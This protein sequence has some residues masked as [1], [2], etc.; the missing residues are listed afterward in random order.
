M[1]AILLPVTALVLCPV[2]FAHFIR[3][4]DYSHLFDN[5]HLRRMSVAGLAAFWAKPYFNLYI[6]ITYSVWWALTMVGSLWGTLGQ[7][8]WLFHGFNLAVHLV[9]ASLVFLVLRRLLDAGLSNTDELRDASAGTI[10]VISALVF[11]IH[12]LQVETVAW[13]SELK[14]ELAALFGLLGLWFHYRS[15]AR[16]VTAT[17]FVAAMLSKPSA[18][19]FPGIVL[20]IDR[21]VL[22]ISFRKCAVMPALYGLLLL[23]FVL[24]TKYLQPDTTLDF[25]PTAA[26]RLGVAANA[27]AFYV[28]KVLVPY[29]LA[30]DYGLSPQYMLSHIPAWQTALSAL[31][32]MAAA[33]VAIDSLVRPSPSLARCLVSC[34]CGIF[35]LSIAPVLGFIPFGFQSFSTVADHYLYVPLLGV[36][37]AVAGILL[38]GRVFA[39]THPI[40]AIVLVVLAGL[41]FQQARLWYSTES[42][43]E[44]TLKVNPRSYLAYYCI[45]EEHMRA[46]QLDQSIEALGR[47]LALNPDYLSADIALGLAWVRKGDRAK[48]MEHYQSVLARNPSTVGSRARDVASIHNN[49]GM[50]FLQIGFEPGAVEHFRKAVQIFPRSLNAHL[51]LGNLA[52]RH[53]RYAEAIAEYEIA[54]SLSPGSRGIEQRLARARQGAHAQGP[55]H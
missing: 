4:D 11:A 34:G 19:V 41:S 55:S 43:F 36:A 12:P 14:G 23:P 40:A 1:L 54:A 26:Q 22:G 5:P 7:S 30:V 20:L 42:L 13:V 21:I 29:P 15:T 35:V 25:I 32:L 39:G 48:A 49:L 53:G 2:L 50:L 51:N 31:L 24:V 8:A 17:C 33:A 47:S 46:G 44:H 3:L 16:I 45:G 37:V 6:P 9:N 28:Y 38:Y 18:I 52:L 10:A 27:F